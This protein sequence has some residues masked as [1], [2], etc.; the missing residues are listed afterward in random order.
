MIRMHWMSV[1]ARFNWTEVV[2]ITKE[3]FFEEFKEAHWDKEIIGYKIEPDTTS[4][5]DRIKFC[6]YKDND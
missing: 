1:L 6:Y 3:Q 5:W 2:A 4:L